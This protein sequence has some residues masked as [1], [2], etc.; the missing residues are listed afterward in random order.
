MVILVF[1]I[2]GV[3]FLIGKERRPLTG[4]TALFA[5]LGNAI[6]LWALLQHMGVI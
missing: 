1:A 3:F 5:V 6:I 4:P 2:V